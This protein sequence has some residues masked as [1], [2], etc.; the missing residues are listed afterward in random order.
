MRRRP[1]HLQLPRQQYVYISF[2]LIT[3]PEFTHRT[4]QPKIKT[5]KW[6][7]KNRIEF[8]CHR[9]IRSLIYYTMKVEV[10]L[11]GSHVPSSLPLSHA[12]TSTPT[13]NSAAT[14]TPE[15][16]DQINWNVL[17]KVLSKQWLLKLMNSSR[18]WWPAQLSFIVVHF[19]SRV[20]R[21]WHTLRIHAIHHHRTQPLHTQA[22]V[23]FSSPGASLRLRHICIQT[24]CAWTGMAPINIS[25]K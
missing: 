20:I 23:S 15:F 10:E 17:P 11:H 2:K 13:N 19:Y 6:T 16:L 12:T 22:N 8:H 1:P 7:K 14:F 9:R 18:K 21:K 3:A 4:P 5:K 24:D 25:T